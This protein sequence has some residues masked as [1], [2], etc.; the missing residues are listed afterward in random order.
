ML[1]HIN[2][3]KYVVLYSQACELAIVSEEAIK[4]AV[5]R[6]YAELAVLNNPCCAPGSNV[7]SQGTDAPDESVSIAASCGSPLAH[8]QLVGGE[9]VLDLGSGGGIDAFRASKLVGNTGEVI[10]I[11]ATPEMVFKARETAKKYNY[12]NVEFRLGEIE[13]MPIESSTVDVVVSNCVLNLVPDKR[14]VFAEIYRVLKP[15]GRIAISDMV[16][17][18]AAKSHIVNPDEWAACIAGAITSEEYRDILEKSGFKEI[19]ALDEAH[20]INDECCSK[21]IPVKS[22]TWLAT[23][24]S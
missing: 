6:R 18:T 10:G 17:T 21:G 22:V 11:D 13:H 8:M 1:I 5:K 3:F 14:G 12:Q 23:K 20:P 2:V 7:T 24:P 15:N 19:E 4:Q 16:A 9:T